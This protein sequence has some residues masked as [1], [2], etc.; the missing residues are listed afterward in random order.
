FLINVPIGVAGIALV[1]RYIEN[2]RAE[3]PEPFDF[4]GMLL[5]G[6]GVGGLAFGLSVLGLDYL[7]WWLVSALI[8][9]GAMSTMAYI[10]QPRRLRAPGASGAMLDFSLFALPAF[11]PGA[12]AGFVFRLGFGAIPFLL[13]FILQAG[14]GLTPLQSGLI[15]FCSA[16]GAMGMKTAVPA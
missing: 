7:P 13:P 8:A 2:I 6:V 11:R 16:L 4:P 3:T 10:V 12:T 15:P 1:T 14:F 9:L 5:A